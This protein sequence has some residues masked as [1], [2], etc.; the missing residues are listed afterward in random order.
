MKL[1]VAMNDCL[2][3]KIPGRVGRYDDSFN[4]NCVGDTFQMTKTPTIL[5]ESGH[6]PNDYDREETRKY[7]F[8][9]LCQGLKVISFNIVDDFSKDDYF[10]IPENNKLF[11][12]FIIENPAEHFAISEELN[13]PKLFLFKE[14]LQN[15]NIEFVPELQ[16]NS[17]QT[18]FAH[19]YFN[20]AINDDLQALKS[21]FYYSDV[22][23]VFKTLS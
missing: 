12:D 13:E 16:P 7:I 6:S 22:R 15:G 20:C 23:N 4:A 5:F 14:V 21:Q 2:Q 10:V 19:K 17:H 3:Q 8:A 1:I 9:A 11:V 18:I